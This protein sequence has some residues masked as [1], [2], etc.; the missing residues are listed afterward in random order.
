MGESINQPPYFDFINNDFIFPEFK[1]LNIK[2][3]MEI[4]Y[5]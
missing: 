4:K 2:D 5:A 3:N 1:P